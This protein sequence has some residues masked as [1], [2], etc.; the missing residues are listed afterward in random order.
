MPVGMWKAIRYRVAEARTA[1]VATSRRAELRAMTVSAASRVRA[2]LRPPSDI[3]RGT[4]IAVV[5]LGA[6][7]SVMFMR[8][9]VL[10]ESMVGSEG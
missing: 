7:G 4:N 3:I 8:I 9:G 5:R 1:G 2:L 6:D 10:A